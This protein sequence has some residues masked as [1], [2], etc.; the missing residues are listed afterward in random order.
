VDDAPGDRQR[1]A[2]DGAELAAMVAGNSYGARY[3]S[4]RGWLS[5]VTNGDTLQ[6]VRRLAGSLPLL[7]GPV[8]WV[9]D[10]CANFLT[11]RPAE[12]R[13]G[14]EIEADDGTYSVAV[15]ERIHGSVVDRYRGDHMPASVRCALAA[16]VEVFRER[17][18][19]R[20]PGGAETVL[21]NGV[22]CDLRDVSRS[23]ARVAKAGWLEPGAEVQVRAG[24]L[25]A[26]R[27]FRRV[28]AG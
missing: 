11:V 5:R 18:E 10:F 23:G 3:D 8:A 9:A 22:R 19:P 2:A 13:I 17:A 4:D 16:K 6:T 7:L 26:L 27:G 25:A 21:V 24:R 14:G 15:G 28:A 20:S 12:R 1:P